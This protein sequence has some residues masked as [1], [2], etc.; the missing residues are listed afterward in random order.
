M[1]SIQEKPRRSGMS[2]KREGMR[3]G[4]ALL[5][6]LLT[7]ANLFC[8]FFSI[9]K[10][11]S[12]QYVTAAWIVV[13]AG[14]FDFA[15]G[16]VARMTKTQSDFGVEYDSLSDLTTFCMAPAILAFQWSLHGF[17]KFGLAASFLYFACGALRL[18]RFNVQSNSVEKEGFQGLPTPA[19]AGM[20]VSYVIFCDRV[21]GAN[22]QHSI[23]FVSM[24][25]FLSVLMVSNVKYRSFK[26]LDRRYSF[27]Y[28]LAMVG[29]IAI[30]LA[31]PELNLFLFGCV[32]VSVGLVEWLWRAPQRMRNWGELLHS[33][34]ED[35]RVAGEGPAVVRG[36]TDAKV[37]NLVGKNE[38]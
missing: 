15:D 10:T 3:R 7:T 38:K 36:D 27:V 12:G 24:V 21:W 6:N 16:R 20:I 34:F 26:K 32:F 35:R 28:L 19:G 4:I 25:V 5:P 17:N 1:T 23:F 11:L 18:A 29:T 33:F 37:V 14:F 9:I 22:V 13:L 30:I 8:G 2:R 31:D